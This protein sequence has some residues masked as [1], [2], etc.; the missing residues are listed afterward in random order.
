MIQ[1]ARTGHISVLSRIGHN[2]SDDRDAGR[3]TL[4]EVIRLVRTGNISMLARAK[5]EAQYYPKFFKPWSPARNELGDT[6][7]A[8]ESNL[9]DLESSFGET[10]AKP[11]NK[12]EPLF[13]NWKSDGKSKNFTMASI[14]TDGMLDQHRKNFRWFNW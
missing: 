1:L 11:D 3:L 9:K 10:E 12:V 4:K 6:D 8:K 7:D 13:G 5:R 14:N 2:A